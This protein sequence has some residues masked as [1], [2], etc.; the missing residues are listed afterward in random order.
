MLDLIEAITEVAEGGHLKENTLRNYKALIRKLEVY[1]ANKGKDFTINLE[2]YDL[3]SVK[4][5]ER[6]NIIQAFNSHMNDFQLFLATTGASSAQT[7]NSYLAILKTVFNHVFN[8]YGYQ[9]PNF[10]KEKT[11]DYSERKTELPKGVVTRILQMPMSAHWIVPIAKLAL[12]SCWRTSDLCQLTGDDVKLGEF[13]GQPCYYLIKVTKKTGVPMRTPVP[14]GIIKY[15]LRQNPIP[16]GKLLYH[17]KFKVDERK[18][19]EVMRK[20]FAKD[21]Y[22]QRQNYVSFDVSGKPVTKLLS[23]IHRPMHALRGAGASMLIEKGMTPQAVAKWFTGHKSLETLQKHYVTSDNMTMA[24]DI[25]K[26]RFGPPIFLES[27]A[28]TAKHEE[29]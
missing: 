17:P 23:Q 8:N 12:Y 7:R 18:L 26:E 19:V 21:Q 22:L 29:E 25:L 15:L 10:K 16:G 14:T 11:I 9:L 6:R 5:T 20:L 3:L 13:M 27:D 28:I 1:Y 4:G 2:E 24:Q